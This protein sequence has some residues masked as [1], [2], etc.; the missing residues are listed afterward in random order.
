MNTA[1]ALV[2]IAL[3]VATA[4]VVFLWIRHRLQDFQREV[5]YDVEDLLDVSDS[6]KL[7]I[8]PDPRVDEL[9]R[10]VS[11]LKGAEA[12]RQVYGKTN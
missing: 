5:K 7:V 9:M 12:L 10:V 1:F 2:D 11:T 6:Q 3:H 4:L 8:P